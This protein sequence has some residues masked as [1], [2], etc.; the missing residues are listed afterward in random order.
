MASY[1]IMYSG[2]FLNG[3]VETHQWNSAPD[4]LLFHDTNE[5]ADEEGRIHAHRYSLVEAVKAT[6]PMRGYTA[7]YTYAGRHRVLPGM[8]KKRELS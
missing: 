5:P 1:T 8:A 4:A 6:P 7:Q 3:N 2:G